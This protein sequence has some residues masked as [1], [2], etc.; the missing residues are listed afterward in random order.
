MSDPTEGTVSVLQPG[1]HHAG[2]AAIRAGHADYPTFRHVFPDPG[3]RARA[4]RAFFG[5]TVRDA[6]P[7]GSAL[8]VWRDG[9]VGATSAWLP[10]CAF[11]WSARRKAAATFAFAQV[12]MADPRAFP[13]FAR[14]GTNV[15]RAH[16]SEPHWYLEVLSVRPEYQRQGLGSRLVAP[17]LERADT[18][19]LPCYL[20]TADPA[21]I[22]FYERFGFE[23]IN[24]A[25]EVIPDGPK[26]IV[27][28]RPV[29]GAEP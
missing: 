20:E 11:P 5:A 15:E 26:L 16:P 29:H 19:Q 27:M 12:F 4:L 21:N 17:I 1:Q 28:Q 13:A 10:P 22:D 18:E 25:L 14:L 6:I 23:V 3:R 24:A 8:A 2:A 9:V 7:F